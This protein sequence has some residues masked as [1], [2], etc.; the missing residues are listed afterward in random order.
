MPCAFSSEGFLHPVALV[1]PLIPSSNV[2][3]ETKVEKSSSQM[4]RNRG[5]PLAKPK[6]EGF[7]VVGSDFGVAVVVVARS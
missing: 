2:A 4:A 1:V 5:T 7:F 6:K 3:H